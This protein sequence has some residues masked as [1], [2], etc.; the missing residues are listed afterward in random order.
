MPISRQAA[1]SRTAISPRLA[2]R[3]F[4]NL[5]IRKAPF[6][7]H[8]EHAK[9]LCARGDFSTTDKR[10][11]QHRASFGRVDHAIIPQAGG[12]VVGLPGALVLFQD[13]AFELLGFF[14]AQRWLAFAGLAG[15]A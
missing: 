9:A 11:A 12:G 2:I 3:I 15:P 7:L 8:P 13:R 5:F 4:R 1:G 14:C 6:D 10:Q